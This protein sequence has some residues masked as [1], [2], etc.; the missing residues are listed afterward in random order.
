MSET[1][2]LP[3][4]GS[5]SARPSTRLDDPANL[6]FEEPQEVNQEI[7]EEQVSEV[8]PDATDEGQE[9]GEPAETAETETES[10]GEAEAETPEVQLTDDVTVDVQGEKLALSELKSGYMREKD[11]RRKTQEVATTRRD[12]EAL[13][14]RVTTSVNAIADFLV[15]QIPPAPDP[16]LAMT[17]PG[18][19]VQRKA[20]H[21]AAVAQVDA[22]L[23]QAGEVKTVENT[24][25]E[26]QRAELIAQESAKLAEAFPTTATPEGRQKF[27]DA[28]SSAARELGYTDDEIKTAVDHRMFK[29]AHYARLGMEAEK[30]REKA[31]TKVASVPPVM[32][33]KRPQGQATAK[34][35][36][37][38]E[39][40]K[41]LNR[42]GS[43]RDALSID[44]D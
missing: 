27:F 8:E 4:G 30:A 37:N 44:F 40:M 31:K 21:E 16:S 13:S 24:L 9:S 17:A 25:T 11:Y 42:T 7:D 19:F 38:R 36:A 6:N 5:D 23:A 41:R 34:A 15:K 33:Q 22:L 20:M 39:A 32:P 43:L 18:E 35:Q 26:K 12:L 10:E 2:N 1:T 28:A 3:S 29:L 14:A